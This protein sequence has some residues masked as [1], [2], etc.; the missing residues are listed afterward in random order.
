MFC[1]FACKI[2]QYEYEYVTTKFCM[3]VHVERGVFLQGATPVQPR[4]GTSYIRPR[5]VTHNS[6]NLCGAGE[7]S[8]DPPRPGPCQIFFRQMLTHDLFA[9]ADI[10]VP[11]EK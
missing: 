6:H 11:I 5:G 1:S 10:L 8:H 3:E 2:H 4:S 9:V 7:I